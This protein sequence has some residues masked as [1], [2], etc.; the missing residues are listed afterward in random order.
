[1]GDV[2]N[3]D[4]TGS[5]SVYGKEF[6][7]EKFVLSHRS[8]GWV[9]MANHGPNTNGCQFFIILVK[10]RWLDNKHVVFGKV[11][12]GFDVI[13]KIS[14]LETLPNQKPTRTVTIEQSGVSELA[15]PYQLPL[16]ALDSITD[17]VS[18]H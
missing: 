1:M 11:I 15:E 6:A 8:P 7:D 3:G 2:L 5:T 9:S 14:E 16:S 17:F 18:P 13:H 4:G 10:A 12:R